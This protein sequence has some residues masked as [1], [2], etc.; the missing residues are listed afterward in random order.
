MMKITAWAIAAFVLAAQDGTWT[1]FSIRHSPE[2]LN[3][4][5]VLQELVNA[6]AEQ[7]INHFCIIG[8]R[9][10]KGDS[11]AWVWWREGNSLILW[12]PV[13]DPEYPDSLLLSRR[14][15][16]LDRDVV[17]SEAQVGSSTYLV[18]KTWVAETQADCQRHGDQF[19]ILRTK[20]RSRSLIE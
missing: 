14:F 6:K 20:S 17:A 5:A 16:D 12:E 15:L 10:P 9:S 3:P 4:E 18:S 7:Q 13:A 19:L 8:Y 1:T 11:H 2:F